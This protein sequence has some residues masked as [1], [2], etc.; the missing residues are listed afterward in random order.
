[1]TSC[2]K[3]RQIFTLKKKGEKSSVAVSR[4]E[5]SLESE[6]KS[7]LTGPDDLCHV[8]KVMHVGKQTV[9]GPFSR[10]K[11]DGRMLIQVPWRQNY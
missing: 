2:D 10:N 5:P 3:A 1:M 7:L 4:A 8:Q 6:E 9:L 11:F